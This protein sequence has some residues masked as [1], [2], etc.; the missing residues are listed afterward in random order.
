MRWSWVCDDLPWNGTSL[1]AW[2]KSLFTSDRAGTASVD[3]YD[4]QGLPD[5]LVL[6]FYFTPHS[7]R[8]VQLIINRFGI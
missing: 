4:K 2:H 1:L 6:A 7:D 5:L 8:I 3:A